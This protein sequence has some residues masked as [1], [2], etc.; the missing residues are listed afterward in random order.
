MRNYDNTHENYE[1]ITFNN[2]R[3]LIQVYVGFVDEDS[4]MKI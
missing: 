2:F 4:H 3:T 1:E